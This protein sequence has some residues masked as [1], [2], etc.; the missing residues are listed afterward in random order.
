M[1]DARTVPAH[2]PIIYSHMISRFPEKTSGAI[3]RAGFI[4]APLTGP[5]NN[6]SIVITPRQRPLP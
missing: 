1:G 3:E 5:P 2:G 4:D 6:A